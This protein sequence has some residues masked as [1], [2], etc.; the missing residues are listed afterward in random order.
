MNI[1]LQL[2]DLYTETMKK[3]GEM[4]QTYVPIIKSLKKLNFS[5]SEDSFP[6][7]L[8]ASSRDY[9]FKVFNFY[10]FIYFF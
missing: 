3:E 1:R 9:L 5:P 4:C 6:K 7:Y 8:D 10:I 2:K